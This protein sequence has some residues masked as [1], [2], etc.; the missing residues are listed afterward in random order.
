MNKMIFKYI[1]IIYFII[2]PVLFVGCYNIDGVVG[3]G[4]SVTLNRQIKNFSSLH[5]SGSVLVHISKTQPDS[6]L[7][8]T[9]DDNL[10]KQIKTF[11]DGSELIIDP[12]DFFMSKTPI[13]IVLPYTQ[14]TSLDLSGAIKFT[15][16][17][18]VVFDSKKFSVDASGASEIS[19]SLKTNTTELDLSGASEI[20][21]SGFSNSF[22]IDASGASTINADK[23]EVNNI[24]VESS[25]AS[26]FLL[27]VVDEIDLDISGA[28]KIF[29]RGN[30]K[31][32]KQSI[33][34]ASKISKLE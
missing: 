5:A 32:I 10:A 8:I 11:I 26:T 9:C 20:T 23:F 3:S 24:F 18:E 27:N 15:T 30:P 4:N 17:D 29:Y 14:L 1:Y 19:L 28:S 6:I 13:K 12:Q 22:H 16:D 2:S 7:T 21:I 33:S 25:G 34:G 31:K